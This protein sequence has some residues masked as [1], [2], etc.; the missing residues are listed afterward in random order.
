M[1]HSCPHTSSASRPRQSFHVKMSRHFPLLCPFLAVFKLFFLFQCVSL[2]VFVCVTSAQGRR[3][4]HHSL[5]AGKSSTSDLSY[6]NSDLWVSFRGALKGLVWCLFFL[7]VPFCLCLLCLFVV[8]LFAWWR[9]FGVAL[10]AA[11][12][13]MAL[14]GREV[15]SRSSSFFRVLCLSGWI[16]SQSFWPCCCP[17]TSLHGC[18]HVAPLTGAML[19]SLLCLSIETESTQL[20]RLWKLCQNV[21]VSIPI[22]KVSWHHS[23][24]WKPLLEGKRFTVKCL[25]LN[26][27]L[28]FKKMTMK[29]TKYIYKSLSEDWSLAIEKE[30]V[31]A[32]IAWNVCTLVWHIPLAFSLEF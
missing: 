17:A 8:C 18:M 16:T 21:E 22:F 26:Y 20:R 6:W 2:S 31:W 11:P 7:P 25:T 30:S 14:F 27:M 3:R 32:C 1:F 19:V 24:S 4:T 28:P 9:M 5:R 29:C 10:P 23:G 12:V 15:R 13:L